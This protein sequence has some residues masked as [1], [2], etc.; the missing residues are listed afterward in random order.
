MNT[1]DILKELIKKPSITPNDAGCMDYI[2]SLLM[3]LGFRFHYFNKNETKNLYAEIGEGSFN[4]CFAGHTD[5]VPVGDEKSWTFPPFSAHEENDFIYGRGTSDMKGG[6]AAFLSAILKMDRLP[7]NKRLSLLLTSDEEGPAI[8]GV[9]YVLPLLKEKKLCPTL[10]IVGEPTSPSQK[11]GQFIKIGRRGSF[12]AKITI[13]G[14]MGHV[15]YQNDALNPHI[16]LSELMEKLQN[17]TFDEG[18]KYFSPTN[19]EITNVHSF[20]TATNVVPEKTELSFNIRFNDLHNKNSLENYLKETLQSL[21]KHHPKYQFFY[22]ISCDSIAEF[23]TDE[24]LINAIEQSVE[25][26]LGINPTCT[27]DG[28]TSDARFIQ[29]Y[30]P[31]VELGLATNQAHQINEHISIKALNDLTKIYQNIIGK[32]FSQQ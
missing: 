32:L 19:L 22:E 26:V 12:N 16:V 21:K 27:T 30:C 17:H 25:N 31:V 1:L 2:E 8:D 4:F 6:I 9:Q 20:N 23:C 10:C 18:S 13:K 14:I 24:N 29:K 5:V 28:A 7:K 11:M 3:P 15:A